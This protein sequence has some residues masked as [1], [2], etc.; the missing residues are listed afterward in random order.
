M[1]HC[2]LTHRKI[3]AFDFQFQGRTSQRRVSLSNRLKRVLKPFKQ[4]FGF[5]EKKTVASPR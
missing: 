5:Q 2:N 4:S 3:D 1:K